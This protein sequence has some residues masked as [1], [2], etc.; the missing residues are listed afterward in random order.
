[1]IILMCLF[2]LLFSI[3]SYGSRPNKYEDVSSYFRAHF[4]QVHKRKDTSGRSL[5]VVRALTSY[6][7]SIFV[8]TGRIFLAFH[9]DA[10]RCF[11]YIDDF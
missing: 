11:I 2:F 6:P 10:G 1:M 8:L 3:T 7:L 9:F 5:Y 4:V